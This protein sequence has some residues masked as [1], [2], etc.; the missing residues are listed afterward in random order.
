[1]T[2]SRISPKMRISMGGVLASLSLFL[3]GFSNP[4]GAVTLQIDPAQ[5]QV[6]YRSTLS[7]CFPDASG[8]IICPPPANEIYGISGQVELE[9]IP[10]FLSPGDVDPYRYLLSLT[11]VGIVS[12]ALGSGLQ[13]GTVL[14]LLNDDDTFATLGDTGCSVPTGAIAGCFTLVNGDTIGAGGIWDGRTLS[15]SGYQGSFFAEYEYTITAAV[16]SVPEP[17]TL[18]L[19]LPA[20]IG[21]LGRK[22]LRPGRRLSCSA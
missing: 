18:L 12:D 10:Q 6:H 20:L 21:L 17:G 13:L 22:M 8:E 2:T 11:P 7:I 3:T 15:W 14:G 16:A 1:M 5:S 9:V 19:T 4:A